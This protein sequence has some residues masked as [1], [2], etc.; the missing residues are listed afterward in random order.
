MRVSQRPQFHLW[1]NMHDPY[2]PLLGHRGCIM[3]FNAETT[4]LIVLEES[5]AS[6]NTGVYPATGEGDLVS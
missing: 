2:A 1:D 5:P 6:I 4:E 3:R